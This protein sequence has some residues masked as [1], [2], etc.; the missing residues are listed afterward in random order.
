MTVGGRAGAGHG[1]GASVEA[2]DSGIP[3][4]V[5][6]RFPRFAD[7]RGLLAKVFQS[8]GFLGV[9]VDLR[10]DEVFVSRSGRGVA[11]GLHFQIPPHAV[12]KVVACLDGA[13]LD[14]VVDLR[15]GSPTF[16]EHRLFELSGEGDRAVVVPEG[17]AHGFLALGDGAL[18]A[19]LQQG[20]FDAAHDA[21]IH[22]ASAGIAWPDPDPVLSAR[23][24]SLPALA[25]FDSPFV[26]ASPAPGSPDP[27]REPS[28]AP[29]P[30]PSPGI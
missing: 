1:R 30:E 11:R 7:E 27:S 14:A 28:P 2:V 22:L 18:V 19:Y 23:D 6:I 12:V 24:R 21:G 20:E 17:C 9:G 15:R 26:L 25:D 4:C 29:S 3:G 10:V 8:S 5:T 16:G 13:I